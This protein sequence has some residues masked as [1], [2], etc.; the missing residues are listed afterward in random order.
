MRRRLFEQQIRDL[1]AANPPG[2]LDESGAPFWGGTR[3]LPSP[4]AFDAAEPTHIDFKDDDAN[5]HVAFVTAASNLRAVCYGLEPADEHKTKLPEPPETFRLPASADGARG[6]AWSEWSRVEVDGGGG[7]LRLS[8]LVARLEERFG[9][10]VSFLSTS[11]GMLLY[12]PLS[13]PASQQRW[14]SMGVG[15]AV[16]EA[17]GGGRGGERLVQLQA[18][19]Y[20]EES[21][22]DVEAPPIL[23][24]RR[25]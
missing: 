2:K 4:A 14:L 1:L 13:P 15:A 23:Y 8:Q 5:G 24:R 7:E 12:S 16:D 10:E 21:E 17:L 22:E 20:D 18:S 3:L 6:E 9:H 19:L 25:D 11:G